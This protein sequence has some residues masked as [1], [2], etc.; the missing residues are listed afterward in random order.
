MNMPGP[1]FFG[2]F[3][4]GLLKKIAKA[5]T[6]P[7]V[8]PIAVTVKAID[9]A[10]L[11]DTVQNTVGIDLKNLSTVAQ[12]TGKLEGSTGSD[13][14]KTAFF[15]AGKIGIIAASAG[16]GSGALTNTQAAA[17]FLA[18]TKVQQGGGLNVGDLGALAGVDTGFLGGID[19]IKQKA[20]NFVEDIPQYLDEAYQSVIAPKNRTFLYIGAGVVFLGLSIFIIRKF[21][22]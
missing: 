16:V 22:K 21:R 20:Q 14:F 13:S 9:K 17:A 7:I 4:M 10:G 1:L 15:D 19:I 3:K 12:Q 6:A 2:F 5:V 18:T 11:T 8:A